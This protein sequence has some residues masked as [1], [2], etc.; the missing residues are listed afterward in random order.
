MSFHTNGNS[1]SRMSIGTGGNKTT[2][3]FSTTLNLVTNSE[4]ISVRGYCSFKST[5]ASYA[6]IFLSS[7]ATGSTIAQMLMFNH[8]GANRGGIGYVPNTG[9][10]RFNNQ[11][12]LSFNTGTSALGG[13][14]RLEIASDGQIFTAS[15]NGSKKTYPIFGGADIGSTTKEFGDVFIAGPAYGKV[16]GMMDDQGNKISEAGPSIPVE[17]IG[18]T[19]VPI[20]GDDFI[21]IDSEAK[22]KEIAE[23]R[24]RSV[25]DKQTQN[26]HSCNLLLDL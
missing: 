3:G 4:I 5:S 8:G 21:V 15:N 13:S 20:S 1:A 25:K 24:S 7:E 2:V 9:E 23:F 26:L 17:T 14:K 16:R 19:G 22:A 10:L 18:L 6:P 11:Y 12:F